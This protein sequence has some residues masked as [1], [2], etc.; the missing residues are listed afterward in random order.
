M[1]NLNVLTWNSTG[2]TLQGATALQTVII[3]DLVANG[4]WPHVIVIQ[5]ANNLSGGLIHQMLA[6]LGGTLAGQYP[7][8]THGTYNSP[9][10]HA[11]E[12]GPSG[13]GYLLT[14]HSS[15]AGQGTFARTD[16]ST[17]MVL[18]PWINNIPNS[19][20]R[21]QAF[22]DLAGM[23]MP[24]MATLDFQGRTVLFLTWHAPRGQGHLTH[25]A[26]PGTTLP[27]GANADAFL[28]LQ[29]S[30]VYQTL[31]EPGMNNLGV[32][33]GDL[34]VT[35]AGL[36]TSTSLPTLRR[37]LPGWVG[38]SG[39]PNQL[40]HILGHQHPGQANPRFTNGGH[41][42]ASGTHEILVSTVAW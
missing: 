20:V 16:L 17:D 13:C 35:S 2:E 8:A 10:A 11:K 29:N 26:I 5:E 28:F 33:A 27:G 9:P 32:I 7:P 24:A 38:V 3:N 6:G 41:F 23:G 15:V 30:R 18:Q 31:V 39:D 22:N 40:D 25:T 36:K 4:W 12:D 14:T 37:I 19:A 1:P 34:N 42:R 21:Q